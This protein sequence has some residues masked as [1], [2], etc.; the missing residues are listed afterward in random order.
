MKKIV[1]VLLSHLLLTGCYSNNS[2]DYRTT[3]YEAP[4]QPAPSSPKERYNGQLALVRSTRFK[5]KPLL[6]FEER[7]IYFG[8]RG[9]LG[10]HNY[11]IYPQVSLGEVFQNSDK[12]A[13]YAIN[14]KRC[15]F[16]VAD[17]G[18][19]PVALI[20]YDG[21]GHFA[22]ES[23]LRDAVKSEVAKSADV[24]L[25]RICS[26]EVDN[27]QKWGELVLLPVIGVITNPDTKAVGQTA[28]EGEGS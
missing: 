15:D 13:F 16:C 6:N 25:V 12:D 18:F 23:E 10:K 14:S 21:N 26:T 7:K 8:L 19:M 11:Y 28:D 5:V 17:K 9:L 4:S 1:F 2:Y 24:P 3:R 27:I 22:N 20:E